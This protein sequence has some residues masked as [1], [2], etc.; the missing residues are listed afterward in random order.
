[1]NFSNFFSTSET[2]FDEDNDIAESSMFTFS[3]LVIHET[4]DKIL[5]NLSQS[6]N[7]QYVLHL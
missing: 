3:K 2:L 1:M 6:F 5:I 4:V 7:K